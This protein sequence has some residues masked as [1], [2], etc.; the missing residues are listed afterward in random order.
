VNFVLIW[1]EWVNQLR[2][3]YEWEY[4]LRLIHHNQDI[5]QYARL[6]SAAVGC[7]G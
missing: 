3:G 4:I 6:V 1:N 2:R 5:G 7:M